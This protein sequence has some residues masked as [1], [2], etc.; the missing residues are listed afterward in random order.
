MNAIRREKEIKGWSRAKKEAL[1]E[2]VNPKWR[3]LNE[4]IFEGEN[5]LTGTVT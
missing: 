3:F 1:V 5:S 4:E 2:S